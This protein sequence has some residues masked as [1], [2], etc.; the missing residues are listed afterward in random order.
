M[1]YVL[2]QSIASRASFKQFGRQLRRCYSSRPSAALR[3]ARTTCQLDN[4]A[5]DAT[6]IHRS[7]RGQRLR[8]HYP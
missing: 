1:Q 2:L 8:D 5:S 6:R 3:V 7:G 4:V